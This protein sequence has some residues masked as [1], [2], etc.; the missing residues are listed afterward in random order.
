MNVRM[1]ALQTISHRTPTTHACTNGD[2]RRSTVDDFGAYVFNRAVMQRMLPP[3]VYDNVINAME[4]KEKIRPEHADT[5]AGAMKDWAI[6]LGATHYTHWFQPLT[7]MSAE[8][9]DAFIDW[10]SPDRVIERFVG[11][12][13]LQGEPDASSFPSGGLR[14][15]FEARGYT[16]WD[17]S[18]PVFVW[19]A[20]SG[21]TLCVPSVYFSWNGQAL[22]HKLPLLR[23]EKKLCNQVLRLLKMTGIQAHAVFSTVG[24]EQEYF[25][26]DRVMRDYR[27]DLA[28]AGRT[29][30]GAPSAKGQ[31]LQDHYFG[32]VKE[33]VL[34]FMDDFEKLAFELGI[35]V[36]TRHNEVAP[37]QH[38]V[39]PVY[40]R[41]SVAVDHNILLM[42]LM[43]KVAGRHKLVCLL[44]EK[45]FA[46]LNGSGKH[47][48]WSL[49]TDTGINLLNPTDTPENNWHF[50][51]MLAAVLT[52]V[53]RHS[54]LLRCSVGSA[55]NDLRLGGHEAPPAIMSI[56]LGEVL[57]SV[58]D[59]VIAG[60][61]QKSDRKK[62][63]FNLGVIPDL[64][65]DNSDRNRTSPFAFTG[66][67]FEFRA[68]GGGSNPAFAVTTL[69]SIVA[70]SLEEILDDVEKYVGKSGGKHSLQLNEALLPVLQK[71]FKAARGVCFSGDNYSAAWAQEAKR[72]RLPNIQK[73][74]YAFDELVTKQA[75][76]A[77]RDVMT[78]EELQSRY[79]VFVEIYGHIIDIESKLMTELFSTHVLPPALRF[80]R[81]LSDSISRSAD[82]LG[83]KGAFDQQ[84][85]LLQVLNELIEAGSIRARDLEEVRNKVSKLPNSKRSHG[86]CELVVEAGNDLRKVVDELETIIDDELW[87]L[88]K[89]R[90][91]L[92]SL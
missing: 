16:G 86:Y 38:E 72:R 20:S 48:N 52:A 18:S 65:K 1:H 79:E 67:K 22:D 58:V 82:V 62:D 40:E 47:A 13:L 30:F 24:F 25:I 37:A 69:N 89:Y 44:H 21:A 42:E 78:E 64:P 91:I 87:T 29:V 83:R 57:E 41:I 70:E 32:A 23:S 88:P 68:V 46:G 9:H 60:R 31:Q 92:F 33:R 14:S 26:I 90:E 17:P 74:V 53:H 51:V 81:D 11:R 35:P 76:Q 63:G 19:K 4:G 75:A 36:K 66:N 2:R 49:A 5:I 71:Y 61:G 77:F 3:A 85:Q 6:S 45:P 43:R 56:Y 59:D 10:H 15:T 84:R 80:Q 12:Q 28:L 27:P 34:S 73:S 54:A 50:L 39:A 55:S 7:G 8:K